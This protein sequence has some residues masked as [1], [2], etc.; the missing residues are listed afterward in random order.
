MQNKTSHLKVLR[1]LLR[2]ITCTLKKKANMVMESKM[3][4]IVTVEWKYRM[5]TRWER[6]SMGEREGKRGRQKER[7]R[8][9]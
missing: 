4:L 2:Y 9:R 6:I 1:N 3:I 7:E 8:H 5:S